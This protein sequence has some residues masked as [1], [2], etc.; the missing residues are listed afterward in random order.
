MYKSKKIVS[1]K[2]KEVLEHTQHNCRLISQLQQT[3]NPIYQKLP[4]EETVS[5]IIKYEK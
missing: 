4:P 3:Y 1:L 2:L 5:T